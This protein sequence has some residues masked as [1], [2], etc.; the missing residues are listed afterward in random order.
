MSE[1]EK[2]V[3]WF[4]HKARLQRETSVDLPRREGKAQWVTV[5]FGAG[6]FYLVAQFLYTSSVSQK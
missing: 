4:S 1:F 5:E 6:I 2:D 3:L